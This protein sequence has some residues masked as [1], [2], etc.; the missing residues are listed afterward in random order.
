MDAE[1]N[2]VAFTLP[3]I[4]DVELL[5]DEDYAKGEGQ[6]CLKRKKAEIYLGILSVN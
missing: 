6:I 4:R 1:R 2:G 3:I 5:S